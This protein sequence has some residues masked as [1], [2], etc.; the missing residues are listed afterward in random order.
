MTKIYIYL[1]PPLNFATKSTRTKPRNKKKE[2][3]RNTRQSIHGG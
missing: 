1:F 2:K 3:K